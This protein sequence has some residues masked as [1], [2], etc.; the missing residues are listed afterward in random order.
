MAEGEGDDDFE[1]LFSF[2]VTTPG[3]PSE[4]PKTQPTSVGSD[5]DILLS[6]VSLSTPTTP[7]VASAPAPGGA[8]AARAP[9]LSAGASSVRTPRSAGAGD[10]FDALFGTPPITTGTPAGRT[11]TETD[12]LL[13][14]PRCTLFVLMTW[15]AR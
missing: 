10:D 6:D 7:G 11:S 2:G 9:P 3:A 8:R 14:S 12:S 5:V 13:R 15:Y 1:D 4:E